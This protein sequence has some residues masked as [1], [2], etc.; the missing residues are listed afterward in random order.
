MYPTPNSYS[1]GVKIFRL[2]AVFAALAMLVACGEERGKVKSAPE[3]DRINK[4][5]PP[6]AYTY[7]RMFI[8]KDDREIPLTPEFVS[9]V[10]DYYL[11]QILFVEDKSLQSIYES[12]ENEVL[13]T[14]KTGPQA[15]AYIKAGFIEYALDR[16]NKKD[17]QYIGPVNRVI[18]AAISSAYKNKRGKYEKTPEQIIQKHE[19]GHDLTAQLN[20]I[21]QSDRVAEMGLGDYFVLPWE[22]D[23]SENKLFRDQ[24]IET[25]ENAGVPIPPPWGFNSPDWENRGVLVAPFILAEENKVSTVYTY[26]SSDPE[27]ICI[28]LPRTYREINEF[29]VNAIICQSNVTSRACIWDMKEMNSANPNAPFEDRIYPITYY[30]PGPDADLPNCR[31]CHIG[32][33]VFVV[34]PGTALDIRRDGVDLLNPPDWYYLIWSDDG[35]GNPP[36]TDILDPEN[37]ELG[38]TWTSPFDWSLENCTGF[39]CLINPFQKVEDKSCI[40]C[41]DFPAFVASTNDNSYCRAV[42]KKAAERTMPPGPVHA[43]WDVITSPTSLAYEK[44]INAL[45]RACGEE[46]DAV[47]KLDPTLW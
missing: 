30:E 8:D 25:C 19:H 28:A 33:N 9:K 2:I 24:Y 37:I 36:R 4:A 31:T 43:G 20:D 17:I 3:T 39:D 14:L 42:L 1:G 34:H 7:H 22:R 11:N 6:F 40:E 29:V 23:N 32:K 15:K 41:H 46:G 26:E 38:E 44:H 18:R 47:R 10:Q 27:G 16:I 35:V 5:E 12:L 21:R 13:V 45:R